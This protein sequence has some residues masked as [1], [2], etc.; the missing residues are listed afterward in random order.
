MD[1][2]EIGKNI[3]STVFEKWYNKTWFQLIIGFWLF[4]G[5]IIIICQ[6]FISTKLSET[7]TKRVVEESLITRETT[8]TEEHKVFFEKSKQSYA[9]AKSTMKAY[10]DETK[11][12]YLFLVEYHNGADNIMTGVSFCK[13]DVTLE[14]CTDNSKYIIL[15]KFKD[16]I[17]A[18]YDI[19]L[20]DKLNEGKVLYAEK[21]EF[22]NIDRYF[23]I[24]LEYTDAQ[25][26]A[27]IN[28]YDDECR[29]CGCLVGISKA[30]DIDKAAI[31][32]CANKLEKIFKINK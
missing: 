20:S 5:P 30:K 2:K 31:Y 10:L 23:A 24:Q 27:M 22:N 17:I 18:R 11:C 29:A 25:S 19:L 12:D 6:P 4:F 9:Q 8:K 15:D 16:D 3:V 1:K 28:L 14:V 13:F 26:F 7:T 32:E 21:P